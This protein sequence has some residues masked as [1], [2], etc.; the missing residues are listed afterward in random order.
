MEKFDNQIREFFWEEKGIDIDI[1]NYM[2]MPEKRENY[3]NRRAIGNP[4]LSEGRYIIKS[5]A[6][7]ITDKF[8]SMSLP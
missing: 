8:L 2:E 1:L 4:N 3:D 6:D 7:V 5:E